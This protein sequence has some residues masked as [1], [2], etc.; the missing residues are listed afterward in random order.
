MENQCLGLA[1]ALETTP[2]VKHVH[3]RFPWKQLSPHIL[4][5]G[6]RRALTAESDAIAPPWP[7]L[8]IATG[9]HS[10]AASLAVREQHPATLRIQ[11]QSPGI[12]PAHFDLVVV[13]R[14]DRLRG[15]NVLVTRGALHRVTGR[16][17]AAEAERW[18]ARLAHLP[19]PRVAVVVGG[20]NNAYRM[21]AK[22]AADLGDKLA[23]MSRAHGAGLMVTP[24]RRTGAEAEAILRQRLAEVPALIWD[25]TGE[26]PY[27]AYLGLADAI[28]VTADS[29]SMTSEACSTGKPVYVA[30]LEGGTAKFAAFHR[31]LAEDGVTRPFTGALDRWTYPP[32]DDTAC[33]AAEVL[34][35]LAARAAARAEQQR[36]MSR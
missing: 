35:R 12:S 30:E 3:L 27:F 16:R 9:R 7:E 10:V 14:H 28:V 6:N 26:N 32:L 20:S 23:R 29:V 24:S 18:H 33:A 15:D 25:G 8:M 17:L 34:K 2:L 21:T 11:I 22:V 5:V 19:T 36:E 1:E 31:G 13:P 4:R